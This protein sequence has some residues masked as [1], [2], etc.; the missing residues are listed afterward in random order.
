MKTL[1]QD[2]A[3]ER[4]RAKFFGKNADESLA[5][6]FLNPPFRDVTHFAGPLTIT[7][8]FLLAPA[9]GDGHAFT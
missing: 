6:Y 4:I 7:R 1:M 3:E 9:G 2:H 5:W 8:G